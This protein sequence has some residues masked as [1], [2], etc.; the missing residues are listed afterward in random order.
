MNVYVKTTEKNIFKFEKTLIQYN[1]KL[2]LLRNTVSVLVKTCGTEKGLVEQN[3]KTHKNVKFM[4]QAYGYSLYYSSAG[5]L[6]KI[7]E[8]IISY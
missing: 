6:W 4:F 2:N 3:N 8:S 5:T 7:F 1:L